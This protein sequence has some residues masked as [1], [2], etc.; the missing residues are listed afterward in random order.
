MSASEEMRR[1]QTGAQI[2][3]H[4]AVD[5]EIDA[6]VQVRQHRRVQVDGQRHDRETERKTLVNFRSFA[7]KMAAF[8]RVL[9]TRW[10]RGS[11]A[12]KMAAFLGVLLTR[13]RRGSFAYKMAA[14]L[15]V[16]LTRWWR[17]RF[18]Y[19]MAAFLKV[20]PTRWRRGRFACKMAVMPRRNADDATQCRNADGNALPSKFSR[21]V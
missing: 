11:F 12:Y 21:T 19:K 4:Q 18:A 6:R 8:L 2:G 9:P 14:F 16:L 5:G 10:R 20:L 3:V 7:Y 17:G 13:W 1:R 15:K